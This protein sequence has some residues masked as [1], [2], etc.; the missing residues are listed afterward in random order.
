MAITQYEE[1]GKQFWQVYVDFRSRKD[2]RIRVQKR[3]VGFETEK[4]AI[5]EEKRLLR[6]LSE[7]L[8]R[9]E[10]KGLKWRDVIDRWE[11][12]QELYPTKKYARTTI[13]DYVSQLRNWTRPWLDRTASELNRGDG[14]EIIR[15]TQA[16]G[17]SAS[18]CRRLKNTINLFYNWGMEEKLINGVQ[19]TP[20]HDVE[21]EKDRE[22]KIPEILTTEEI[23]NLLRTARDQQHPWYPVWV[24][25]VFTGCRSGELQVLKRSDIEVVSREIAIEQDRLLP[26]NR[27]YGIIRIRRAWNSRLKTVGPTKAGHWRSVPVSSQFYWFLMNELKI[28][29]KSPEEP[30]L[31]V[32]SDWKLGFQAVI[33][34]GF[35]EANSLPS[36]K[37]HTLRACFATQLIASGVPSTTVMKIGGWKDMKTMQIYVRLAGI[38]EN[39]ATETLKFIPTEQ[40]VME[41]IVSLFDYKK[42]Q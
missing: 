2:R 25:A 4:E 24:A 12:Y 10:S 33:L 37:F 15:L 36:I 30:L 35:C 20:V 42:P 38:D 13:E 3:I 1:D 31:P 5:A 11:R 6:E 16:E 18:F 27:K 22:E 32:S 23:K 17:K 8:V 28:E 39:G 19:V 9:L 14:R 21:I 34:R 29:Q 40:A 7:K 41:K 26:E